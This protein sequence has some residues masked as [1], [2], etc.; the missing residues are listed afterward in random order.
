MKIYIIYEV[1]N[2]VFNIFPPVF[3]GVLVSADNRRQQDNGAWNQPN[4]A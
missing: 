4:N 2:N 3:L 1:F